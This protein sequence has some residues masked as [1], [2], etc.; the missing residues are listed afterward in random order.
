MELSRQ[1]GR[2]G[3]GGF[4]NVKVSAQIHPRDGYQPIATTRLGYE[5][6]AA[7]IEEVGL[8]RMRR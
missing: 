6:M 8:T 5:R 2:L 4:G 3:H 7:A 1:L